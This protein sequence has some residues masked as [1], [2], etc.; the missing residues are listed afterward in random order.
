MIKI[1]EAAYGG[2][3]K[4][5]FLENDSV[6]L[7]ITLEVGPRIICYRLKDGENVFHQFP[8]H[9]GKTGG[10]QWL[11]YGGHRLWHSPEIRPRT[12][13]ADNFPVKYTVDGSSVTV[14][15]P[16]DQYSR[17]QKEMVITLAENSSRVTV[18]HRITNTGAWDAE[19]A[20]WA[21]TVCEKGG[22]EVISEPE[23]YSALLPNRK[24]VLWP[25]SRMN[26]KRV[27]WGDKFVTIEQDETLPPFKVG[28]DNFAGWGAIFVKDCL[29]IKRYPV[30]PEVE[31]ADMGVSYETYTC[32]CMTECESLSPL[33][34]L[35]PGSTGVHVEEWELYFEEKPE[36]DNEKQIEEILG[37][38]I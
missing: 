21:I 22:L 13:E 15:P 1:Y 32:N 5:L 3:Q 2:W 38:Y 34:R 35:A 17:T 7:V 37:K 6:Q 10:N 19:L 25:Y 16:E 23:K 31:Y 4:C 27:Y 24:V 26:D 28:F 18:E 29:F 8:E 11:N 33:M 14:T 12:Y 20:L 30:E 9:A 36:R